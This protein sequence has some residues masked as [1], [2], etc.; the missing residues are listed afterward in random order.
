MS[1]LGRIGGQVLSDNLLRAG[2][3]LAFDTNLLYLK[4]GPVTAGSLPAPNK[5]D[6]DPNYGKP[7]STSLPARGIGIRTDVPVYDLDVNSRIITNDLDIR[8]QLTAGNVKIVAPNSF[9]TTVGKI[10]VVIQGP[11]LYHDRL[12]TQVS[13]NTKLILDG[14]LISSGTNENII[15]DPNG[16]GT[17]EYLANTN[18][19]GN[20]GVNG[21]ISMAGNLTGLGTL[22]FGDQ[23][24]DTLTINT[25]FTQSIIP[26][27]DLAYAIGADSADSSP[28]RWAE[29]H[30][31]DWTPI[32]NGPWA[33]SGLHPQ[34]LSL[35]GQTSLDGV[36]NK[37]QGLQSNE[38]IILNP[39]TGIVYIERTKWL[40]STP[41]FNLVRTL[42]NPNS[43]LT[44]QNDR[45]GFKVDCTDTYAVIGTNAEDVEN[46]DSGLVYV[47]NLTTGSL[48][49]SK[50]P[51]N[52]ASNI[53]GYDVAIS[54]SYL[55]IGSYGLNSVYVHRT[56]TGTL[57][58]TFNDP[59]T[60]STFGQVI[61]ISDLY[62]IVGSYDTSV[63]G[64]V[65]SGVVYIYSNTTGMLLHTIPNPSA[66]TDEKFGYSVSI[67]D[68]YAVIGGDSSKV[69]IYNPQT[70][71]LIKIIL[72]PVSNFGN[73]VDT[74]DTYCLIGSQANNIVYLYDV[75]T[76][77]ML[78]ELRSPDLA[79]QQFGNSVSITQNYAI[80]G[81]NY[82]DS[83]VGKSYVFDIR[84]G[85]NVASLVNPNIEMLGGITDAFGSSVAISE[86]YCLVSAPEEKDSIPVSVPYSFEYGAAINGT[87]SI[88]IDASLASGIT[89]VQSVIIHSVDI[90]GDFSAAD[91][92]IDLKLSTDIAYDTYQASNDGAVYEHF[93]WQGGNPT[94]TGST[95][96]I[97]F[98]VP[99]TVNEVPPGMPNGYF[100]QI[101]LNMTVNGRYTYSASGVVYVYNSNPTYANIVNLNNT[102]LVMTAT[103]TGYYKFNNTDGISFPS[104]NIDQRRPTPELGET[105]WNTDLQ[106][107]EC[108]DGT[109]W[110]VST[111]GGEEVT[112][113]IMED[114]AD[115]YALILG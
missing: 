17:I 75:Y 48:M 7:L 22:T 63:S 113:P 24:Y 14:N 69:Y 73:S 36:I 46:V 104:G 39:D 44:P 97:D 34:E 42:V 31:P 105:R 60:G 106:Y 55:A 43:D 88:V 21:N 57:T 29:I 53:V 65:N 78:H 23:T 13:G 92:Y 20:V 84:S 30:S 28:R 87:G 52:D 19:T 49:Y 1:Q 115:V 9:S 82:F 77:N 101:K 47:Y 93:I 56:S 38:D 35:S 11:V 6:G 94:L 64:N 109:V 80:V 68:S 110:V 45:F 18:V 111:G 8:N 98:N 2:V 102:P 114:L 83:Q 32:N 10:D 76:G 67:S 71:E 40:N 61:D 81:D 58:Y 90:M 62:T 51:Y 103:G 74:Y 27:V 72:G 89:D 26:G 79:P 54:N 95:F 112:R 107:L 5:E 86:R 91:E 12:A 41:D 25:D 66:G 108:F 16:S 3:D 33:G 85:A 100:W 4:V 50:V 96:T 37:I 15:F 99:P 70:G 59:G